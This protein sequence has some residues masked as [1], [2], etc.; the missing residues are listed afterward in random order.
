MRK[1]AFYLAVGLPL[2]LLLAVLAYNL[3]PIHEHLA[4]RVDEELLKIRYALHPPEQ[5][6]FV[7]QETVYATPTRLP[8]PTPTG[9]P[10][11]SDVPT[12]AA[13]S[14]SPTAM[15]TATPVPLPAQALIQ[16]VPYEDQHNR[17]NYCAPANLAMA[18]S[19]WGWQGNRDT[20]G[21]YLK[22][23]AKDK[24]VMPYE[25]VNYIQDHTD[26]RVAY[27]IAGDLDLLKRFVAAGFPVLIEKGT[28]LTDLS[29]VVSWMGHYEVV[30]GYDDAGSFFTTQDSY[31]GPNYKVS[32]DDMVSNW[33]AFD[34]T[35][36]IIYPPQKEGDVMQLL[37]PDAD[38][39]YNYNHAYKKASQEIYQTSGIDQFFAWFN[40]GSSLVDLQDYADAAAAYDQA[41]A[42]VY[43]TIPE[44]KRPWR[45]LWYQTGP[46]FAY[47]YSGR[48]NDVIT[49][50]NNTLDAM[51]SDKN[52][53]ESYYWRGMAELALGD[54]NGAVDDFQTS[55]QF[56]KD[57]GPSVYELKQLGIVS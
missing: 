30:I 28:Y 31:I 54:R 48:Y 16:N 13:P 29:G 45:M 19:F 53:E 43:P 49:L 7:P 34:Y 18:L 20:V 15:P 12:D 24:N 14:P 23:D 38:E 2:C 57:F 37:G 42:T 5:V 21:P 9:V 8:S 41:F 47:F 17:Y 25:M 27:R 3:P 50:A 52:L 4:W 6:I 11:T 36:L 56:H 32:F 39:S 55:L 51:Q 1:L 46:Y 35:Y 26:L 10:A 40:R 44:K 22:P 33:R